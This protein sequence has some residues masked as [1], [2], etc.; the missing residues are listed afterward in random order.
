MYFFGMFPWECVDCHKGLF[1]SKR[2][3]RSRRHSQ[4]EI[5]T[6]TSAKPAVKP[7][8]EESPSK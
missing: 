6:G 7:G 3:S 2:Y 8:S 5:Y 1:S 4:G